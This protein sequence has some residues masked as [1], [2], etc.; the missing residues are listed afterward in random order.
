MSRIRTARRFAVPV[1]IG[2]VAVAVAAGAGIVSANSSADLPDRSAA[3]LLVD[4][5]NSDIDGLSGTVVQTAELGLPDLGEAGSDAAELADGSKTMRLWY[6]APDQ[7]RIAL[8]GDLGE[9][10]VIRNGEDMWMWNSE[11]DKAVH[12]T[13]PEGAA[14]RPLWPPPDLVGANPV[15]A[16]EA[17]LQAVG[18][19]TEVTTD[20]SAEVADRDA[21]ELTLRPKGDDSLIGEVSLAVDAETGVPLRT[22]VYAADANEPAF[23]I[24]FTRVEFNV[25]DAENFTFTA[26]SGVE[27]E[28][29]NDDLD[30][31]WSHGQRDEHSQVEVVGEG[32]SSVMVTEFDLDKFLESSREAEDSRQEHGVDLDAETLLEQF[33]EVSGEWGSG[34]LIS[35]TLV[36]ALLV[37]DGRLLVGAVT[38]ERLYE[39][40]GQE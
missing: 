8:M 27:V 5:Q 40:A 25:P 14:E 33:P 31:L 12:Y 26:P 38:P 29:G 34:R 16:A 3:E 15:E 23:E 13:L 37:D 7:A 22:R 39:V 35:T 24:A 30:T 2:A 1:S 4:I 36:N 17:A 19:S 32:W 20:G 28:E 6:A 11:S 21:Y 10:D 9:S 18:E